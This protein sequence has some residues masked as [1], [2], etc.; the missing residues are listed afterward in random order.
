MKA[1]LSN[2]FYTKVLRTYSNF[3]TEENWKA[4]FLL[5]EFFKETSNYVAQKLNFS[6]DRTE[7]Q[8]VISYLRKQY[9]ETENYT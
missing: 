6:I 1:Y 4:L 9:N 8:N 2:D 3:E 7:A 5:T